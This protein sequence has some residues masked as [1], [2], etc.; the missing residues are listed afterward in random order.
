MNVPR[1]H[2]IRFF[3]LLPLAAT[4]AGCAAPASPPPIAVEQREWTSPAGRP[5]LQLLT[6]HYDLRLT[7]GDAMLQ[8]Y[9]APFME[10][11]FAEYARLMPSERTNVDRLVVYLFGTRP[12]WAAF[13]A[14]NYPHQARVYLHIHAGGFVDQPTAT[15][16][17]H[18]IGR[19][20]TL[21]LLAHEGFHQYLAAYFPRRVPPWLNEGLAT[22][23]EEFDL[24][25]DRPVFTPRRNFAR[26][27]DLR[28][29]LGPDGQFIPL[30]Q[31]LRM[32]A[33]EA[34]VE[35][36][37]TVRTYYAQVWSTVLFLRYGGDARYTEGFARLLADA[38]TDRL[39]HAIS[40]YRA[41]KTDAGD[42]SDGEIVFRHY[43]SEDLAAFTAEYHQFA[44]S[45]VR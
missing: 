2:R 22:Q 9:L 4:L 30:P 38:G 3:S 14:Q 43:L 33:G 45:L 40:A 11:A 39:D 16:V 28:A 23:F 5:G 17:V 18:D 32:N 8:Q 44:Q 29:A 21:S 12:E 31:L 41:A 37:R 13:T 25:G 35:T 34:V 1:S 6:D 24:D 19:D 36:G 20:R 7:A 15:A 42:L 26:S 27:N 10:T